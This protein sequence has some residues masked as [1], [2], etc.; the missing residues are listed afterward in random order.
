[1]R[2]WCGCGFLFFWDHIDEFGIAQ[3]FPAAGIAAPAVL[4]SSSVPPFVVVVYPCVVIING[5]IL[6]LTLLG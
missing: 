1:L 5:G 3:P 2:S 4:S 6:A